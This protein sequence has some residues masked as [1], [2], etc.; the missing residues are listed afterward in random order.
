MP[1]CMFPALARRG[2]A[3]MSECGGD[4][5]QKVFIYL[6]SKGRS[7]VALI[8][9]AG[10]KPHKLPA[11]LALHNQA[12]R[13]RRQP[14]FSL[15]LWHL[16]TLLAQ[17]TRSQSD[18]LPSP[19]CQSNDC[20]SY[21]SQKSNRLHWPLFLSSRLPQPENYSCPVSLP[22]LCQFCLKHN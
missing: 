15:C 18:P 3:L 4:A 8:W 14:L 5:S 16:L 20:L 9:H 17:L 10:R 22:F 12:F 7:S 6:M 13:W 11:H 21:S 19:D 2:Q 1:D